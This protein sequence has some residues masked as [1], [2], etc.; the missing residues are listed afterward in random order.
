MPED[1]RRIGRDLDSSSNLKE[2]R[3]DHEHLP[4]YR[5]LTSPRTAACSRTVTSWPERAIPMA[6][7][8]PPRPAPTIPTCSFSSAM[9]SCKASQVAWA[10]FEWKLSMP[11]GSPAHDDTTRH[12]RQRSCVVLRL[13][14]EEDL[15]IDTLIFGIH[16]RAGNLTAVESSTT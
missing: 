13:E 7:A 9:G 2:A 11:G 10:A 14:A 8:N 16:W 4:Q 15:A 6:A 1:A 12:A 5:E 3:S